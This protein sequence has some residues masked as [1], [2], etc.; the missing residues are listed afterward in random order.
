MLPIKDSF[1]IVLLGAWNPSIFSQDWVLKNLAQN[2]TSNIAMAFPLDDPT[3][4]RKI[5]FDGV[6]LFPGRKQ[7]HIVA[8][9]LDP[10]GLKKCSEIIVKILNLLSH[11]P[12][13][14]CGINFSFEETNNLDRLEIVQNIGDEDN[15]DDENYQLM[16]SR[17]SRKFHL[18]DGN[19]LNL[20]LSDIE[21]GM[22]VEF[23]YHYELGNILAY[24][25]M[26][27]SDHVVDRYN[28]VIAFCQNT[29]NIQLEEGVNGDE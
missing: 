14:H 25:E 23:N 29:Y 27:A 17:I 24:K 21:N 22:K 9:T 12:V 18:N 20:S 16:A 19:F 15:I 10:E 2:E 7:L 26:F 8:G 1:N 13:G 3:A 5:D 28:D 11:T 4:P 6:S